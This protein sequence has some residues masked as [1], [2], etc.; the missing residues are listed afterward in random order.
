MLDSIHDV[1]ATEPSVP[2]NTTTKA[3]L[4]CRAKDAI[5]AGDQ[6]LHDAAEALAVAREDFKSSQREIADAVGK[7]VA[8]VNRLLQW[9]KQGFAG[10]PFGPSSKA[11]RERQKRVQAPEQRASSQFDADNPEV[12]TGEC[13]VQHVERG[14]E[15]KSRAGDGALLDFTAR[16]L[17]LMTR[18]DKRQ[19]EYFSAAAVPPDDLAK[20]GEFLTELANIT[21][22]QAIEPTPALALPDIPAAS[23]QQSAVEAPHTALASVDGAP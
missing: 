14:A 3:E 15:R 1:S 23:V 12:S 18:I 5:A 11:R 13:K 2:R 19:P 4:F 9:R 10:T 8:W 22:S 20:L 6:S 21:K 16:V 7:S 17:D